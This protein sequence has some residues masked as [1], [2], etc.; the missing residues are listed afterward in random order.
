[1]YEVCFNWSSL[2]IGLSVYLN[3]QFIFVAN[4]IYIY[5]SEYFVEPVH[6]V[7]VLTYA[8]Q[9]YMWTDRGVD[10]MWPLYQFILG[11]MMGVQ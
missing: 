10:I 5:S 8:F 2:S 7:D 3:I 4:N 6:S 1:M 9:F 11:Y